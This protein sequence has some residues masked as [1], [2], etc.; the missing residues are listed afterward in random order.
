MASTDHAG[1]APVTSMQ[2]SLLIDSILTQREEDEVLMM[3]E[4]ESKSPFNDFPYTSTQMRRDVP[5]ND[6]LLMSPIMSVEYQNPDCHAKHGNA[7]WGFA[8]NNRF[9]SLCDMNTENQDKEN[10]INSQETFA[11]LA[12]G[13]ANP[14]NEDG[15]LDDLNTLGVPKDVPE[16]SGDP[17][18]LDVP[19]EDASRH[20][21]NAGEGTAVPT[22]PN[23]NQNNTGVVSGDGVGVVDAT[24]GE[25]GASAV[26]TETTETPPD[27]PVEVSRSYIVNKFDLVEKLLGEMGKRSTALTGTVQDLRDSLEF[28]QSEIVTLKEENYK[29]RQKLEDLELEEDRSS[30]Q[31][32]KLEGKV[33][34]VETQVK[35]K[36]LMFE[37]LPEV[38]GGKEEVIK[39]VWSLFDQLNINRGIEFDA[40]FRQGTYNR[41]RAR[42]IVISFQKQSD[43]D[44]VYAKRLN[45]RNTQNYKQVWI[46]EDLGQASKKARN[47]IRLITKKAQIDGIDCRTGK[48]T[49]Q[50]NNER[51]DSSNLCDLPPPLHP[52][53]VKQIQ[54]DKNTVAYQSEFAPFSNFFPAD[55]VLGNHKFFC[56]E[57]AYQ[58]LKAKYLNKPLAAARIYLSREQIEIKQI[59]DA[60]GSSPEWD[61]KRFDM[62]YVCLRRKFEQ[63]QH[64]RAMLLATGSCELVEATPNRLWGCGAT[65][66]SNL[67]RR[68]EWPG[69]NRQGKI[70]MTVRD[71]LQALCSTTNNQLA[72]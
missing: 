26:A 49:L 10:F 55:I 35:K 54:L 31:I 15:D 12:V 6:S 52:S 67:L 57:Q 28:S 39:T 63:N 2:N 41:H 4:E 40:C 33:D 19:K 42:P 23:I 71:E 72:N 9:A 64:L 17:I 60:L 53:T 29:L 62:M 45:L 21:P 32:K 69:E 37:G 51:Y 46:S 25:K 68:H 61:T 65:L 38:E 66:S 56:L 34:K 11:K 36:N 70:L 27:V 43:R 44:L 16:G 8:T 58:Y 7:V 3:L 5:L 13:N 59:G 50:V 20:D 14:Q 24:R 48:Y 47:L 18:T 22:D 1:H 30:Y